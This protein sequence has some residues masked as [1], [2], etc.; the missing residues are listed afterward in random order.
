MDMGIEPYL[1]T[2]SVNAFLAQRLVRKICPNCSEP[3][4]PDA[5]ELQRAGLTKNSLKKGVLYRGKGCDK[6]LNTGY[7]GRIGIFELLPLSDEIKKMIM[8]KADSGQIKARGIKEG[9]VLLLNDGISK[10]IDG[11]TTLEEVMRVS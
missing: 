6:C 3:Y 1:I 11:T 10:V 4:K 2:S 9:M 8:G 5:K 7:S